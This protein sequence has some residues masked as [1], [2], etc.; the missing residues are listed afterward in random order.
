MIKSGIVWRMALGNLK[1]QWKQTLLTILAGGIGAMLIA[2]SAVN[3]ESVQRSGEVW[4]ETHLGPIN[5]RLTPEK[6]DSGGFTAE[7]TAFLMEHAQRINN[8]FTLLPYVKTEAAVFAKNAGTGEEAALKNMLFMGFSMEDAARLDQAGAELWKDELADDELIINRETA[9]LLE[10]D[11]GDTLSVT[12]FNGDK[13]F[14]IRSVA[15]QR[16]LTG[17]QESGAFTGTIIGTERTVRELSSQ[18]G[19][20]YGAILAGSIDPSADLQGMSLVP[21]DHPYRVE[22][23]KS[24][25]KN[26]IGQMNYSIIIGMI[27]IIAI[28]SSML[29]MRQVLV[30][31]GESRQ[32]MYGILRAIGFSK[33]NIS[34]MFIV[35]AILLSLSSALLGTLIGISGGYGLI[36]MFYGFYTAELAR[37]A[38]NEIPIHPYVSVGTAAA[39]FAVILL[40]LILISVFAARKVSR[41][42]I[43]EALRGPSEVEGAARSSRSKRTATRILFAIGLSATCAH[44]IFAFAQLPELNNDNMLLIAA[45]WLIACCT[46]LSI[47][48]ALLDK[49][50]IPL[51][52]LL[53]IIGLPPLSLMLAVKYPRRHRGR[54]YVAALMFALVMM[55]ITFMV[56]IMQLI[57]ASGNVDRTNQT[58]FGF[59]GYASYRT[60][61]EK[62]KI[63]TAAANDPFIREHIKGMMSAE[64]YMLSMVERGL[65]QAAVPV[66]GELLKNNK[67]RLLARSPAFA[68]DEAAWQAVLNDPKYVVLPHFYMMEDPLFPSDITLVKAGDSITLPI[69]ESKPRSNEE[70]WVP[71][72]QRTFIVAGFV[73]NDAKDLLM[74]FYGATFMHKAVVEELRPFG[75]KWFNQIDLGFVLFQLD[76]KDIKLAQALEERFAIQGVLNFNVPYLKNS[77]EQLINKQIGYGF[78]GFTVISACIGLMGLAIIQFRAVRER[79]KQ[80]GMMRCIGLPGKHIYWMFFIE[81]FVIS[82]VGLLVGLGIGSSGAR[83]FAENVQQDMRVFEEPIIYHYPFDILL[84]IIGGLLLAS[85]LINIAPARAAL[86]LKAADA[87]RMGS[88]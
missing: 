66:T 81:G 16:G 39:V 50:A 75:H 87:L 46:I 56:C 7:E 59:G 36:R 13:L 17:Y 2:I 19:D 48:L 64:P 31:I 72:S 60:A 63:E 33:G 45:T 52:R 6:E 80:V 73:P 43:V 38:G 27:S 5:W 51:Q 84:P 40:F 74:D 35:E 85:L 79:S 68:S 15:E 26:K 20:G 14:R 82:A 53:R 28:A 69:Y 42:Q 88:E 24:D 11:V 23:V 29:F 21:T 71:L 44:L 3:Y 77:A 78:V 12:T 41:F 57:L 83:I 10:V 58:V 55:T 1:K 8:G 37:M 32:E 47:V 22:H 25:I 76:Y 18:A 9:K 67:M 86:K 62:M 30:M 4:I 61:A 34:A 49:A 65:A 70:D 54:T